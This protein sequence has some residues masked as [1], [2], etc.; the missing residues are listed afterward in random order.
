MVYKR[1][2]ELLIANEYITPEHLNKALEIQKKTPGKKIG[3]I[4]V[5]QGY[6]TQK[7]SR[8]GDDKGGAKLD[9]KQPTGEHKFELVPNSNSTNPSGNVTC[10]LVITTYD[11]FGHENVI[12]GKDSALKVTVKQR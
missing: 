6:T 12:G 1:L 4:L 3:E 7:C 8:C 10:K 9:I 11:A 2:G 5:E